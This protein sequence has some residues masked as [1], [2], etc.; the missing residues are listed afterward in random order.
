MGVGVQGRQRPWGSRGEQLARW[1][2]RW[3]F[4]W[5]STLWETGYKVVTEALGH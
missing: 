1:R 3:G 4:V 5:H 2:A